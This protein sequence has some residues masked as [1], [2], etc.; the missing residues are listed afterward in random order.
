M[1]RA[2]GWMVAMMAMTIGTSAAAAP[3]REEHV[4]GGALDLV[5]VNGYDTPNNMLPL[6]LGSGD[7][8]YANPSGDHT[9]GVATNAPTLSGGLVVTTI[10]AQGTNDYQWE[11]WMF[12]G[13]GNTRRGLIFRAS[14][15]ANVKTFYMFVLEAGMLRLRFRKLVAPSQVSSIQNEWFTTALPGGIPAVNSWHHM[16]V[17]ATGN[18]FQFLWD[19][20]DVNGG[21]PIVD[22][23]SPLTFGNVGCYN[24]SS[25]SGEVPV[26]FDDLLLTN[27]SPVPTRTTSWGAIKQLYR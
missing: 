9:V 8:A 19:G 13:D 26:Y 18:V 24:F 11:G 3:Y 21:T 25:T 23:T 17:V 4:T 12:T 27:L 20:Q 14:P 7:P 16:K 22:A 10:D 15:A 1:R 6:T 2:T 5:W